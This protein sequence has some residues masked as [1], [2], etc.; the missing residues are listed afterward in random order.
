MTNHT[1]NAF[2][3]SVGG[4]FAISQDQ[5]G[6]KN[7]EA[8]VFHRAHVEV[9]HSDEIELIEVVFQAKGLF[10]PSLRFKLAM[11]WAQRCSSPGSTWMRKAT[12]RPEAVVN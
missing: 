8:L 9:A 10:I 2:Q 5:L 12:A 1:F 4:C 3:L 6:I 7:I 11:A